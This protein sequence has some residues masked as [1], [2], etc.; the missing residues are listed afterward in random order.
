[1]NSIDIFLGTDII[2]VKRIKTSISAIGQ[3]FVNRIFTSDEQNYC[4]SKRRPEIHFAGRFAAKES[5][6]KA[7]ISSGYNKSIS[8]K[9][10]EIKPSKNGS[11]EVN[12]GLLLEG[13]IKLSISHTENYAIASAIYLKK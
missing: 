7:L 5:V 8:F 3:R 6:M 10:I 4:L 2:E 13:K 11:P 9:T 1:M 12:L